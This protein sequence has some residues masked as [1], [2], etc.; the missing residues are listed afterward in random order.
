MGRGHHGSVWHH[1]DGNYP[2]NTIRIP[3]T[4]LNC[5]KKYTKL[6]VLKVPSQSLM[7]SIQLKGSMQEYDKPNILDEQTTT[8]DV[9]NNKAYE[10]IGLLPMANFR[11]NQLFL[12]PWIKKC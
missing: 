8:F 7:G 4:H 9:L 12:K 3:P 2:G 1:Q 5:K 6:P 10:A 11:F